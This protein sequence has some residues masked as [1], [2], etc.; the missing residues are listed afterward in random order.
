[1]ICGALFAGA[2]GLSCVGCGRQQRSGLTIVR[3]RTRLFKLGQSMGVRS[4][5]LQTRSTSIGERCAME[6]HCMRV[7]TDLS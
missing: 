7:S 1:M 6:H 4:H 5:V 3:L 2:R